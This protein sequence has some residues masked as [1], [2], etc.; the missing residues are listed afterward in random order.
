[1][2]EHVNLDSERATDRS[3]AVAW[4]TTFN[5]AKDAEQKQG[6]RWRLGQV[7][8]LATLGEL[9]AGIAH[10]INNPI[11]TIINCGQLIKDGDTSSDHCRTII[12]E[13]LR[14]STIVRDLLDFTRPELDTPRPTSVAEVVHRASALVGENLTRHGISVRADIPDDLPMVIG[15]RQKLLQVL[16]NLMVNARDALEG[17]RP[18]HG[19]P[20]IELRAARGPSPHLVEVRVRDNGPGVRDEM[21]GCL[22]EALVTSKPTGTGLGLSI[23]RNIVEGFGGTLDFESVPGEFTEFRVC[24]RVADDDFA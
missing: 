17:W 16:L 8:R 7:E 24:L 2:S 4:L 1:M 18:P 10:E 19:R 5:R 12:E 3:R 14:V 6:Q 13:G 23:S 22:F 15:G 11:N 9:A 21:R 20:S